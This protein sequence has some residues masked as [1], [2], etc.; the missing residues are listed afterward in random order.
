MQVYKTLSASISHTVDLITNV[1]SEMDLSSTS[2][3]KEPGRTD[4]FSIPNQIN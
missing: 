3:P 2:T 1:T 4:Y